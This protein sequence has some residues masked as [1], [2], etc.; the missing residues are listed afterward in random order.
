MFA[1]GRA[2]L[3]WYVENVRGLFPDNCLDPYAL[4]TTDNADRGQ[5]AA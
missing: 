2:L 5:V 4:A 1:E 3:W